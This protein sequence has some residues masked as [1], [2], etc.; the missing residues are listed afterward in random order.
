MANLSFCVCLILVLHPLASWSE[1][2]HLNTDILAI[3]R[4]PGESYRP[5]HVDSKA[6]VNLR[7]E[8]KVTNNRK[9]YDPDRFS[10]GGPDPYHHSMKP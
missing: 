2:R 8:F 6:I 5:I 1:A 9:L 7:L 4:D 10:P 3:D